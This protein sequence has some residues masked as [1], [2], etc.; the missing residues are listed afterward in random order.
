MCLFELLTYFAKYQH[1]SILKSF[2]HSFFFLILSMT[3]SIIQEGIN[4]VDISEVGK[5][6]DRTIYCRRKFENTT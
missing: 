5:D 6:F 4:R 1:A 2:N 3:L